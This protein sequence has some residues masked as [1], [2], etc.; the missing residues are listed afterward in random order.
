M[1]RL[2][3]DDGSM[4]PAP[5]DSLFAVGSDDER[6]ADRQLDETALAEPSRPG[7]HATCEPT[8]PA[9][10]DHAVL[11]RTFLA[12]PGAFGLSCTM[13]ARATKQRKRR[14]TPR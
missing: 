11:R 10:I 3:G 2:G 1:D 5:A 7:G 8:D 12:M 6:T 13:G 9:G 14:T 4:R